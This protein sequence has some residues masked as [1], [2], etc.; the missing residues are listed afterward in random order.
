MR[1]FVETFARAL[2][3]L[4]LRLTFVAAFRRVLRVFILP[5]HSYRTPVP[6]YVTM[7]TL[8]F[9]LLTACFM[10]YFAF[11]CCIL[12]GTISVALFACVFFVVLH[13]DALR[14]RLRDFVLLLLPY[15]LLDYLR[16]LHCCCHLLFLPLAGIF[17]A[18]VRVPCDMRRAWA[19][20]N[21]PPP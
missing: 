4:H 10:P 20:C 12:F 8:T 15:W 7:P 11:C 13:C 2:P 1:F 21:I 19:F 3:S 18:I 16:C 6:V 9:C 14:V 5:V 17:F